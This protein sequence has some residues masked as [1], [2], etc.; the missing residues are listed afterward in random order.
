[1]EQSF[2]MSGMDDKM[3]G[4]Y[5]LT[6]TQLGMLKAYC[7]IAKTE[8]SKTLQ[9]LELL[10]ELLEEIEDKQ[11]IGNIPESFE[12]DYDIEIILSKKVKASEKK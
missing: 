11:F 4:R 1:M 7:Q 9:T 10:E 3:G 5:Y 2:G 12:H 8:P 6:G